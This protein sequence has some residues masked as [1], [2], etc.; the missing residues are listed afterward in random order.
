VADLQVAPA[1]IVRGPTF[2]GRF[3]DRRGG[4]SAP[5]YDEANLALHVGDD[6]MAVAANRAVLSGRVGARVVWMEQV[7]GAA[8]EVVDSAAPDVVAGVDALVT[9]STGI[10]LA[11]LVADCVPVLLVD[12]D[13]GVVAV[14][15][16]GRRGLANGVIVRT[17]ET[18]SRLGADTERV[19][20]WLGPSI[21]G[22]CYEVP[23]QLRDE[24][25]RL[26]PGSA[27][28]TRNNTAGIDIRAGLRGQLQRLGVGA[29]ALHETG[30]C[31]SES[32]DHYSH[33]RD[34][35]TGRFAGVALLR[36]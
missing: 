22:R 3:T 4:D 36:P 6:A 10:A 24:V 9:T 2:D 20:V 31:T 18:M 16:A 7:H 25:E 28:T 15:H 33:R 11:V 32:P 29:G 26:A 35:V 14:A 17:V 13:V 1:G 34:G 5:P 8:V 12:P 19:L 27:T 30:P 21:C 23:S